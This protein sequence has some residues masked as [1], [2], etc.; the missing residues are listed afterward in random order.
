MD[1]FWN[2]TI[3]Q[4]LNFL[5]ALKRCPPLRGVLLERVDCSPIHKVI[6]IVKIIIV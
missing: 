5:S 6:V 1:I 2:Y 3:Q 4:G